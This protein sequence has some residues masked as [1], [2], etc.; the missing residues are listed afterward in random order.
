ME[1]QE[2]SRSDLRYGFPQGRSGDLVIGLALAVFQFKTASNE[3]RV[4]GGASAVMPEKSFE[5]Q[6]MQRGGVWFPND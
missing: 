5:D 6:V 2:T 4:W 3:L 1:W